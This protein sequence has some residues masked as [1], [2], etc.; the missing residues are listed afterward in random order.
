[1]LEYPSKVELGFSRNSN[2]IFPAFFFF[3]KSLVMLILIT[4]HFNMAYSFSL[5]CHF[6]YFHRFQDENPAVGGRGVGD[7]PGAGTSRCGCN[8]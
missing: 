3:R 7:V 2:F 5:V 1:M 4:P 6:S 8:L